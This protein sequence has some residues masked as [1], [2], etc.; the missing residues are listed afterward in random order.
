[1]Y[2]VK[3]KATGKV[4]ALKKLDKTVLIKT[5]DIEVVISISFLH[6]TVTTKIID[7]KS[8]LMKTENDFLVKLHYS[9]QNPKFV[10]LVMDFMEGGIISI[11]IS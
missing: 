1:M 11:V 8:I 9:F 6:C 7:E 3:H 10:F 5:Q 2:K 4:Y